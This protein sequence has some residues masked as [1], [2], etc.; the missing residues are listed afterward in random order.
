MTIKLPDELILKENIPSI[1]QLT[2]LDF[3]S[4]FLEQNRDWWNRV[5]EYI[6]TVIGPEDIANDWF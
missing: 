2:D 3:V 5:K 1:E 4:T 6:N